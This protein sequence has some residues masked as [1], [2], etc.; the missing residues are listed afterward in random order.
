MITFVIAGVVTATF[1]LLRISRICSAAHRSRVVLSGG[2]FADRVC[3]QFR[4][5]GDLLCECR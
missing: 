5:R 3:W 1:I 4:L 2:N